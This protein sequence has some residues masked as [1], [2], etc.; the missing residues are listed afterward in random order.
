[1]RNILL[2]FL[3]SLLTVSCEKLDLFNQ[4]DNYP[5][6][7]NYPTLIHKLG[8]D[9]LSKSIALFYSKNN[10]VKTSLNHFGFCDIE[11][12][13]TTQIPPC[14]DLLTNENAMIIVRSFIERNLQFLGIEEMAN[15]QFS[16]VKQHDSSINNW[17]L[18]T[19]NQMVD[20]IEVLN[21]PI[22]FHIKQNVVYLCW[23]NWFPKIYI[24]KKFNVNQTLAKKSLVNHKVTHLTIAG[25]SYQVQISE[26]SIQESATK[27]VIYPIESDN[28]I[29]LRVTWQI[30]I[31]NPVFYKIFVDVMTGQIITEM[32]TIIS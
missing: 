29:E 32:P 18:V 10:Y 16:S 1:M 27:L 26:E 12:V 19:A 31:P 25:I 14:S 5:K 28:R 6:D 30:E 23:G 24:P 4:Q 3:F 2:V 7:A 22:V 15:V 17:S 20:T 13:R 21:T 8:E 11:N 9:S